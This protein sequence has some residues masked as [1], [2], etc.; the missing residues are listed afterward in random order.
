MDAEL[1]EHGVDPRSLQGRHGSPGSDRHGDEAWQRA[2]G[3]M[4][5]LKRQQRAMAARTN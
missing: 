1:S 5:R 4:D 3:E 2:L